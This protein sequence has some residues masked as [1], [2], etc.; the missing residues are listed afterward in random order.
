[1]FLFSAV[2]LQGTL[3]KVYLLLILPEEFRVAGNHVFSPSFD[4][5]NIS[6]SFPVIVYILHTISPMGL[7]YSK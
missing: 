1:M 7:V 3:M 4:Q 5:G 2:L 6:I